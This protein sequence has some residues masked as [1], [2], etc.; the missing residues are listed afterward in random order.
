MV[1]IVQSSKSPYRTLAEFN[2]SLRLMDAATQH[3]I[4]QL[5]R[6]GRLAD[7]IRA[8]EDAEHARERRLTK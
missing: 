2:N 5:W 7:A 3:A 8:L 6:Q 1:S 4:R